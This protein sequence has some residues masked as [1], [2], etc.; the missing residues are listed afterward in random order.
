MSNE[1]AGALT[2][3]AATMAMIAVM[4]LH[5]SGIHPGP[6]ADATLHLNVIVHA[7]AIATA[8]VLTFGF[9]AI[10]RRIGFDNTVASLAFFAYLFGALAVMMAAAMSGLVAPRLIQAG[11]N[12][13]LLRLEWYLNQAFATIHVALFSA[14][15]LLYALCWPG[16]GALTA[17]L[18]VT[19]VVIGIGVLAWMFSG[20][21]TL[22]VHGMGAV[23][24]AQGVWILLAAV[25]LLRLPPRI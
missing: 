8:P 10:T 23:V 19:G 22:N 3:M 25:A 24:L 13:D 5:P 21:L 11:G 9:F 6:G 4:A 18:Q 17:A 20:T 12:H 2:L 16:K 14:A 1:R 15:I 7:L